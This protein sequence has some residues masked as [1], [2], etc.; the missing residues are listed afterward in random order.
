MRHVN[1]LQTLEYF[2][3]VI[4]PGVSYIDER[5]RR[6]I[7]YTGGKGSLFGT[8]GE[9]TQHINSPNGMDTSRVI[10]LTTVNS[11]L[12]VLCILKRHNITFIHLVLNIGSVGGCVG[13]WVSM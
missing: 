12:F 2:D 10:S 6:V 4:H 7:R 5:A 13:G 8:K 3:L 1:I 9:G 11:E